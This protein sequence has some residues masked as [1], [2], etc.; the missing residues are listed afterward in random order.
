MPL[1][2]IFLLDSALCSRSAR[3]RSSV[4]Q[5]CLQD[6]VGLGEF[7]DYFR[8]DTSN[9]DSSSSEGKGEDNNTQGNSALPK[10]YK[11]SKI[12]DHIVIDIDSDSSQRERQMDFTLEWQG[13]S[14]R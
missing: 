4:K 2:I 10:G 12:G 5:K 1:S 3:G 13:Y 11:I 14:Q 7:K 8:T 9:S 6:L